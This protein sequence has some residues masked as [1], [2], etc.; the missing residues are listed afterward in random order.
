MQL[1]MRVTPLRV[2]SRPLG[3]LSNGKELSNVYVFDANGKPVTDVY[4]YD[5]DGQPI[6]VY[7]SCAHRSA[8]LHGSRL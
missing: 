6:E 1:L 4:F 3:S 2:V 5:Q 7:D 8:K